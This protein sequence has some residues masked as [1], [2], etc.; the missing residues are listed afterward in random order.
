ML[1]IQLHCA[2]EQRIES[3]LFFHVRC[4]LDSFFLL[5]M[6]HSSVWAIDILSTRSTYS[7]LKILIAQGYLGN[8]QRKQKL[9]IIIECPKTRR[10]NTIPI[11]LFAI[12]FFGDRIFLSRV[13]LAV[14]FLQLRKVSKLRAKKTSKEERWK[15]SNAFKCHSIQWDEY[16]FFVVALSL[17]ACFKLIMM[18]VMILA[19]S[20]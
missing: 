19:R 6:Q 18:M 14:W 10:E 15:H 4:V 17:V 2:T 1:N 11:A 12:H 7:I 16:F 8:V 5:F 3:Y 13:V 9:I 20:L